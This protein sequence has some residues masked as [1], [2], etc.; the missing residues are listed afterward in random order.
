MNAPIN[1]KTISA[2]AAKAAKKALANVAKALDGAT[3]PAPKRVAKKPT[4]N[5]RSKTE[6]VVSL[7]RRPH[8]ASLAEIQ[9]AMG[10]LPHT[11]R[12]FLSTARSKRGLPIERAMVDGENRYSIKA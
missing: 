6:Q 12:A 5:P 2:K 4:P 8:G 1:G 10:W 9:K 3:I 7:L 11:T